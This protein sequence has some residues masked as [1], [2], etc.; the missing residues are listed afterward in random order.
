MVTRFVRG[1][2]RGRLRA[3]AVP[4]FGPSNVGE[5]AWLNSGP[6]SCAFRRVRRRVLVL[7]SPLVPCSGGLGTYLG[8]SG[9]ALV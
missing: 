8:V 1:P 5:W 7:S 4:V 9:S 6:W 2:I 3:R